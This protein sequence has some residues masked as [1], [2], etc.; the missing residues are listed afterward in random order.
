[1]KGTRISIILLFCLTGIFCW[2]MI[3]TFTQWTVYQAALQVPSQLSELMPKLP[4]VFDPTELR[5]NRAYDQRTPIR[6]RN[7]GDKP[8]S[9]RMACVAS[10]DL[11]CGF[12]WPGRGADDEPSALL[13]LGAG[14]TWAMTL[15]VHANA[16]H[17]PHRRLQ[18]QALA[19]NDSGQWYKAAVENVDV[20]ICPAPLKL[21]VQWVEPQTPLARSRLAKILHITNGGADI[22]DFSVTF[23]EDLDQAGQAIMNA[24]PMAG[25]VN[26]TPVTEKRC[27]TSGSCMDIIVEP[28][29]SAHFLELVGKLYL[30]GHGQY[31]TVD[32]HASV[33]ED[34]QLFMTQS[35]ATSVTDN[36]GTRSTGQP[37][38][39]FNL[40]SV[41]VSDEDTG[42][43]GSI[44]KSQSE[45]AAIALTFSSQFG[46]DY[47]RTMNIEV[48]VNDH[49]VGQITDRV[50]VGRYLFAF[51]AAYLNS[52]QIERDT[53]NPNE[54]RL[55]IQGGDPGNMHLCNQVRLYTR[56]HL[57]S[58]YI[59]AETRQQAGA[60]LEM[61][62][63]QNRDHKPD[64][65]LADNGWQHPQTLTP[66]TT[67]PAT[68]S[69]FNAGDVPVP[70]GEL[71]AHLGEQLIG[72]TSFTA[73]NPFC[74]QKVTVSLDIPA[75]LNGDEPLAVTLQAVVFGDASPQDNVISFK[76]GDT[77][78]SGPTLPMK[79]DIPAKP[80]PDAK[81]QA[82]LTVSTR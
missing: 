65:I 54:I 75:Q 82:D 42:S 77:N 70:D 25:K 5:I 68:V 61:G 7:D 28:Q 55:A 72:Q 57:S 69:L 67:I 30:H 34:K 33:P 48:F 58:E 3:G 38:L 12:V 8:L 45:D 63:S 39:I 74:T 62:S 27:F 59:L 53:G 36:F 64:L 80:A 14:E 50:P 1:M 52:H 13:H 66:G 51:P 6:L 41:T 26:L 73:L 56:Q 44:D 81:M 47:D 29:L 71:Q 9:V 2:A 43:N 31:V 22:P 18:V 11:S 10:P 19:Q 15:V 4:L 46:S 23:S 78:T 20:Q 60:L 24:G 79:V 49:S 17:Y 32:Y 37:S 40:P 21:K 76:M 35:N 16:A